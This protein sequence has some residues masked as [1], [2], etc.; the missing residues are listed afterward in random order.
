MG[1]WVNVTNVPRN[2]VSPNINTAKAAANTIAM[3]C[4]QSYKGT[5]PLN[6]P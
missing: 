6:T 1:G 3:G 5:G 2:T 4:R